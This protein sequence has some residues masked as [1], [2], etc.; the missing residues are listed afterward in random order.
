MIAEV[1]HSEGRMCVIAAGEAALG[2]PMINF[3]RA[4]RGGGTD[5][6]TSP[7]MG[8][9]GAALGALSRIPPDRDRS[10]HSRSC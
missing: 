10:I 2:G 4:L 6:G 9:S 1:L 3:E 7:R 8:I 5:S